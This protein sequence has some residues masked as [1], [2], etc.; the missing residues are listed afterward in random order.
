MTGTGIAG[1]ACSAIAGVL[2]LLA[3]I[4]P[5]WLIYPGGSMGIV[6]SCIEGQCFGGKS[7]RMKSNFKKNVDCRQSIQ[8]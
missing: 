3:T 5:A 4:L 2:A 6:F 1:Y 8:V 7:C